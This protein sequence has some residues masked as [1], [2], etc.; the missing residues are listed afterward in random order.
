MHRATL[1]SNGYPEGIAF[2][3]SEVFWA[4]RGEFASIG[5]MAA[6]GAPL[7]EAWTPGLIAPRIVAV[8]ADAVYWTSS[9]PAPSGGIYRR[10]KARAD[11]TPLLLAQVG[12]GAITVDDRL[13][14]YLPQD[15]PAAT[16]Y[17]VVVANIL[18][19]ALDALAE[20][21]AARVAAGGRIALSGILQGQEPELLQRYAAW[22]DD[23]QVTI[24]GVWVRIDGVRR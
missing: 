6:S 11:V 2:D 13:A 14:V 17:P 23:L 24:D 10:A 21:L 5:R 22:F 18:A 9:A 8:D 20:V 19:T 1:T 7:N 3:G 12:L 4:N 16:T 15:E